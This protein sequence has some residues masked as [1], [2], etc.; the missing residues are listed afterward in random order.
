MLRGEVPEPAQARL[1]EAALVA[2]VDHGPHAPS[3]A[4]ARMAVT[5]GLPLNGAM[6]SAIN[7]LDDVHGGAGQQ[8]MELYRCDRRRSRRGRGERRSGRAASSSAS[9]PS[10]ARSSRASAIAGT[11]STR[12]RCGC[13][14]W[15]ARREAGGVVSRPVRAHRQADRAAAC[16]AARARPIP[17]NIDGATAVIYSRARLRAAARPRHLHPVALGR[18]PRARLGADAAGR[19]HQGADAAADSLRYTG[20]PTRRFEPQQTASP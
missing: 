20:P 7:A 16:A 6:A 17:M 14:R 13:S 4:I 5:C 18:H 3:I 9:S 2:A 1:L 19:A 11:A 15:F 12:A 10:T 8:C